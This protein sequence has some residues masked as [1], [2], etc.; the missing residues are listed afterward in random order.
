VAATVLQE[1]IRQLQQMDTQGQHG[2]EQE[3]LSQLE[4]QLKQERET[5][6]HLREE[7]AAARMAI[8]MLRAQLGPFPDSATS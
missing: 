3:K 4:A 2:V 6:A 5:S 1:A 8:T 7:L